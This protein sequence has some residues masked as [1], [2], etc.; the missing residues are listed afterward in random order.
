[1]IF[2]VYICNMDSSTATNVP[3]SWGMLIMKEAMNEGRGGGR[4]KSVPSSQ[5]CCE[6]K[7]T[8]KKIKSLGEKK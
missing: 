2:R 7:T 6:P 3:L 4:G 1:M 5:C 8:L